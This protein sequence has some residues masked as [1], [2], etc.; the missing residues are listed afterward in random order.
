MNIILNGE[1]HD[2]PDEATLAALLDTLDLV[3]GQVAIE[4]NGRVVPRAEFPSHALR[5]DDRVEIVRFV[6]GG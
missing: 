3:P 6:G 4:V 2:T 1:R 5:V